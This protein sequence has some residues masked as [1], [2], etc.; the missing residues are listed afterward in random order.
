MQQLQ[1][2]YVELAGENAYP[3]GVATRPRHALDQ[4]APDHIVTNAD[5]RD[6]C[7]RTLCSD[8]S[9]IAGSKHQ[10]HVLGDEVG[11]ERRKRLVCRERSIVRG[12]GGSVIPGPRHGWKPERV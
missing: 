6:T 10:V 11:G 12:D 9:A 4:V 8:R 3:C 2:L 1:P 5:N 7:A